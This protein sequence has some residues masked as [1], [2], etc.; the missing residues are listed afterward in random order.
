MLWNRSNN[1]RKY[2]IGA[3]LIGAKP[4]NKKREKPATRAGYTSHPVTDF[5]SVAEID[6]DGE[7]H[8][9]ITANGTNAGHLVL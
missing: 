7:L 9:T 3:I 4:L 6:N 5:A 2:F 8:R 1:Y